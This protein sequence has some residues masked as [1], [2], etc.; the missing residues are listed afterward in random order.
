MKERV[1]RDSDGDGGRRAVWAVWVVCDDGSDSDRGGGVK[2][3]DVGSFALFS[4]FQLLLL[5]ASMRPH[6]Y[7]L[8]LF[9]ERISHTIDDNDRRRE[10]MKGR[11]DA[12]DPSGLFDAARGRRSQWRTQVVS[13]CSDATKVSAPSARQK[14]RKTRSDALF[15]YT[16]F[17][18]QFTKKP[19]F[20]NCSVKKMNSTDS[21]VPQSNAA[22]NT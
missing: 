21:T 3:S 4:I 5:R 20:G 16:V 8:L 11:P 2:D 17:P 9:N 10:R 12:T 15:K 7:T 6:S 14:Y 19:P 13:S 18:H 1:R 22:V